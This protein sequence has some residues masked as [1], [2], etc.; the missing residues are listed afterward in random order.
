MFQQKKSARR[1][2]GGSMHPWRSK[3]DFCPEILIDLNLDPPIFCTTFGGLVVSDRFGFAESLT[4][5]PTA[6]HALLH[7]IVLNRHPTPVRQ[8]HIIGLGPDAVRVPP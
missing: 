6:I 4:R 5:Y 8:P 1:I 3:T 2:P 7:H